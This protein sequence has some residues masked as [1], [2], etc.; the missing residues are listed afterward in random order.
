MFTTLTI[1]AALPGLGWSVVLGPLA[2]L[3]VLSVFGVFGFLVVG[4][5]LQLG[6]VPPEIEPE[7]PVREDVRRNRSA[8]KHV[9]CWNCGEQ[10][11][12]A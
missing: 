10:Q 3:A 12:V 1:P 8:T 6:T 5:I 11:L 2:G 9:A 4:A 7:P